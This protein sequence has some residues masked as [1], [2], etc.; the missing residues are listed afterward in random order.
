MT[1]K[2]SSGQDG[3]CELCSPEKVTPGG[4]IDLDPTRLRSKLLTHWQNPSGSASPKATVIS[5]H[6][7]EKVFPLHST[8][9]AAVSDPSLPG[10]RRKRQGGKWPGLLLLCPRVQ[11]KNCSWSCGVVL[12]QPTK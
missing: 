8:T 7:T 12:I 11:G 5:S 6:P 10:E 3:R 4:T 1:G 9:G 2:E